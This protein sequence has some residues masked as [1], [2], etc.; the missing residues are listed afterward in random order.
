MIGIFGASALWF[1]HALGYF[2]GNYLIPK[3]AVFGWQTIGG[4]IL[5][6]GY[7]VHLGEVAEPE[8]IPLS[9]GSKYGTTLIMLTF[10]PYLISNAEIL[11]V[12]AL[13]WSIAAAIV[14]TIAC[15]YV[16]ESQN[17][18]RAEIHRTLSLKSGKIGRVKPA[19]TQEPETPSIIPPHRSTQINENQGRWTP[20]DD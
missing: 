8:G 19:N 17:K 3:I 2:L 10:L 12:V 6:N 20:G 1:A 7:Y 18:D 15:W 5:C 11:K 9:F 4:P 16:V 14:G 13:I